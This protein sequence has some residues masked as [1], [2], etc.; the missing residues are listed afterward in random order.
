MRV[1]R[2]IL[3]Q[4]LNKES[5]RSS[6]TSCCIGH[7]LSSICNSQCPFEAK[8]DPSKKEIKEKINKTQ[9]CVVTF[10]QLPTEPQ[11]LFFGGG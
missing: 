3:V 8:Q 9:E 6:A 1:C 4:Y 10:I 7:L 2:N 5:D 11:G